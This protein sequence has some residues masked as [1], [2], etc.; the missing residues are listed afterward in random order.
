MS[1]KFKALVR[2]L[3]QNALEALRRSV[4]REMDARRQKTALQISDIHPQM[5][6]EE[7]QQAFEDI[8]R[9]LRGSDEAE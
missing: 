6:A 9:V 3:D 8:A 5:S 2:D 4:V 1:A 7:K